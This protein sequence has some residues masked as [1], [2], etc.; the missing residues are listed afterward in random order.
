MKTL[1]PEIETIAH[2]LLACLEKDIRHLQQTISYLNDM[3]SFVIKRDEASLSKLLENIHLESNSYRGNE[4]NR[5]ST[6]NEL[7]N[8]LDCEHSKITLS[9]LIEIMPESLQQQLI[10]SR[11]LLRQLVEELKAE[12]SGTAILLADCTRFNNLLLQSLFNLRNKNG[13][14]YTA[15]GTASRDNNTGLV[16]IKL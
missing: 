2:R 14:Y 10:K 3:R 11:Q 16:N 9:S 7:A 8:A 15:K 13:I 1:S 12:Y 6:I 5:Q 4:S